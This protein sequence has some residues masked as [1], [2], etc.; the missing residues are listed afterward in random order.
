MKVASDL[1]RLPAVRC[2]S[3]PFW[4]A[5]EPGAEAPKAPAFQPLVGLAIP[6]RFTWRSDRTAEHFLIWLGPAALSTAA[7]DHTPKFATGKST[8]T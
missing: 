3:R 8:R 5:A 6:V 7:P 2:C 1:E 4:L